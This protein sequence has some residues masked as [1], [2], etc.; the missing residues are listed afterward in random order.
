[1]FKKLTDFTQK[2]DCQDTNEKLIV[3]W[4][5]RLFNY[6]PYYTK[7]KKSEKQ[8]FRRSSFEWEEF[9]T[10]VGYDFDDD[11]E[12]TYRVSKFS[13]IAGRMEK[14]LSKNDLRYSESLDD[15]LIS[16]TKLLGLSLVE[17]SILAFFSILNVH[18]EFS[19]ACQVQGELSNHH[20]YMFLSY[21]L[22]VPLEEIK[23]AL[24]PSNV[25]AETGLLKVDS[26]TDS[27]DRKVDLISGL[28]TNLCSPHTSS[29]DLLDGYFYQAASAELTIKD[30][31]YLKEDNNLVGQYLS[32]DKNRGLNVLLYGEPGTGKTQWVKA[33]T[34][35]FNRTLYEISDKDNEG[36]P[37]HPRERILAYRMAQSALKNVENSV[38]IFDEIEDVFPESYQERGKTSKSWMNKLIENSTTPTFW[39][40]NDISHIDN[41]YIRRFD[42]AIEL[43]SPPAEV[44][45]SI[46]HKA[47]S[48]INVSEKWLSMA[49][50]QEGLVPG[51][52]QRSA[53]FLK[54]SL[55][56]DKN[57]EIETHL[58]SII[59][60]ILKAQGKKQLIGPKNKTAG[61]YSLDYVN[62]DTDLK[63][64]VA[65]ITE[66]QEARLCLYGLPGTGK[67]AFGHFLAKELNKPLVLKKASDLLGKYVGESEKNIADVFAEAKQSNAVL[68]IDEA[69]SFIRSREGAQQSWEVTQVNEFLTQLENFDGVFIASTNLMDSIDDAAMRRFDLKIEFKSLT[70]DASLA[71]LKDMIDRHNGH[72]DKES[73]P[74]MKLKQLTQ[75]TPGDFATVERKLRFS[76]E[77]Y[78]AE[79]IMLALS[80]ECKFKKSQKSNNKI[81]FL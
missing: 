43:K 72:F 10:L 75:L 28:A 54:D 3:F 47:L 20:L 73:A 13:V 26:N 21:L 70:Y 11:I 58:M 27:I 44:I 36:D 38:L 7:L 69:D 52:I 67:T 5:L 24:S 50:K 77:E 16:F 1:M 53:D 30:F 80:D 25:L 74:V 41:A 49:S 19:E 51:V 65:A 55:K 56:S 37:M 68:Q 57:M 79:T 78:S 48:G 35:Q 81:G 34:A 39:I 14:K 59:N 63:K 42:Y 64:L 46:F 17:K 23:K 45:E 71:L 76:G 18:E 29:L 12:D 6:P 8:R 4:V 61:C 22:D 9:L 60:R 33:I 40:S 2:N 32:D 31:Y 66:T 62:S 15:N